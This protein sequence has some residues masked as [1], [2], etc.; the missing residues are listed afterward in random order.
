VRAAR[1]GA[2]NKQPVPGNKQE[3]QSVT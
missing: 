1:L 2:N 3:Q